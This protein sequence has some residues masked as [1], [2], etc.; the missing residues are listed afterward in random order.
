MDIRQTLKFMR[1]KWVLCVVPYVRYSN[2]DRFKLL[3]SVMHFFMVLKRAC[4][5]DIIL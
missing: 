1:V 4:D 5:L 3:Y 2:A